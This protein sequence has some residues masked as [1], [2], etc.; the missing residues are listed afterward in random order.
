MN[1]GQGIGPYLAAIL[2]QTAEVR[3]LLPQ[4]QGLPAMGAPRQVIPVG[5]RPAFL[6]DDVAPGPPFNGLVLSWVIGNAAT[7]KRPHRTGYAYSTSRS[8]CDSVLT[9]NAVGQGSGGLIG[10]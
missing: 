3:C 1:G 8:A 6:F 9:F 10:F 7:L 2:S 5:Q 4:H